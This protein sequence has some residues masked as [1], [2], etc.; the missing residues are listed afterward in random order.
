MVR[1]L[2]IQRGVSN[3]V[4]FSN[5]QHS[6]RARVTRCWKSAEVLQGVA[7]S[8]QDH[9]RFSLCQMLRIRCWAIPAVSAEVTSRRPKCAALAAR[10][11]A[12]SD[13][14]SSRDHARAQTTRSC[15]IQ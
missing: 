6:L 12:R 5:L 4:N 11:R 8:C 2:L 7:A 3:P 13:S 10:A 9:H 1:A 15:R 14:I